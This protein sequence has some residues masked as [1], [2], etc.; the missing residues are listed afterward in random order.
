MKAEQYGL[1]VEERLPLSMAVTQSHQETEDAWVVDFL[2]HLQ[3]DRGL[4]SLSHR[5][6]AAAIREFRRGYIEM[7][8]SPPD[9]RKL[10]RDDFRAYL[11]TL[12][13]RKLSQ[14]A[15][16]LRFSALRTFYRFLWNRGRVEGMPL[17]QLTLPSL[18]RRLPR[19]LTSDQ[20]N[21][22][23]RAP[24]IEVDRLEPGPKAAA[25]RSNLLRD[26]AWLEMLYSCGLRISEL[27]QLKVGD[28]EFGQS[29][30]RVKG[31]GRKERQLPVGEPALRALE[32]Y[33]GSLQHRPAPE[34]AA[35]RTA[36]ESVE[37]MRPR[38]AQALFKRY[39]LGAGLDPRL[40]PHKLRHSFATHLLDR[41]ADLRS[42][43][44]LLGHAHLATTEVYTH[45]TTERLRQAYD[46]AHPRA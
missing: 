2:R 15:I 34:T 18:P 13:R 19:F 14:A 29:S 1:G 33:W 23:L 21:A 28:V 26:A 36:L 35:F 30:V 10:T 20:V 16:R 6:Y 41:G 39:L 5:N 46:S 4:S 42:V 22:L 17:R 25:Q 12:G 11:R 44:E 38:T 45:V 40:T 43:Q 37:P 9:W 24:L 7:T 31:K 27:C 8:G 3:V 32:A